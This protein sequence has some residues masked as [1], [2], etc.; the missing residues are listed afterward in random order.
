GEV[1]AVEMS[2]WRRRRAEEYTRVDGYM[3]THVYRRSE[4]PDQ[5]F[6]I[7]LFLVRHRK[8]T[9]GP[10]LKDFKEIAQADFFFGESWGNK[11]FTVVNSGGVIGVRTHAWGTFLATCRITFRDQHRE[12]IILHRY[13]D[14]HMLQD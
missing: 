3:L 4:V 14:F 1:K 2:D 7:F 6:D 11:V 10:P 5:T 8:G 13:V 9:D 12:P